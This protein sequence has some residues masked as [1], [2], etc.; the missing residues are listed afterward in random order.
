MEEYESGTK[1]MEGVGTSTAGFIGAAER[2]PV[3][4]APGLVTDFAEFRRIYGGYLSADEYGDYRFLAYAVKHFFING[5]TRAFIA[6]VA[7]KDAVCAKGMLQDEAAQM[8][9]MTASNPGMWGNRLKVEISPSSKAKTQIM[10][11]MGAPADKCY[12]VKNGAGFHAGDVVEFSNG[13]QLVYNRIVKSRD[14]IITFEH[15][16]GLDVT[17]RQ[18]LP[19]KVIR[20]CEFN[21]Q[22]RFED[23]VENYEYLSFNSSIDDFVE[24]KT[25]KSQLITVSL[26]NQNA[27]GGIFSGLYWSQEVDYGPQQAV[28]KMEPAFRYSSVRIEAATLRYLLILQGAAME[29]R[30]AWLLLIS[31]EWTTGPDS[32]P[33]SRHFWI[34]MRFLSWR[35]LVLRTPMCSFHW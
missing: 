28:R 1:P 17:D 2:G 5:G 9:V 33:V 20:T 27:N 7:P 11:V 31:S 14:N 24:K 19:S 32:V 18:L 30:L 4:G 3:G 15:E 26:R 22:V 23:M 13:E 8:L 21:M 10:E 6:R 12:A 25:A 29:M 34:M 35:C 16:F